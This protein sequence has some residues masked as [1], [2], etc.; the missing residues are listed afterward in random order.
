[1]PSAAYKIEDADLS[2]QK[3]VDEYCSGLIADVGDTKFAE[4]RIANVCGCGLRTARNWLDR[5]NA[6]DDFYK[7]KLIRSGHFPQ[8]A[9][10]HLRIAGIEAPTDPRLAQAI[11]VLFQVHQQVS[12]PGLPSGTNAIDPTLIDESEGWGG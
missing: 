4:K 11:N 12:N 6:P 8:F 10:A 2:T 9:A 5:I 7:A 1:M 3:I